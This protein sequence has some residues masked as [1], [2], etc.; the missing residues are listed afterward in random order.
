MT[1]KEIQE[2]LMKEMRLYHYPVAVKY[3][4]DQAEVDAFKEKLISMFLSSP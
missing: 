2:L 1:Y 4:F 3:F